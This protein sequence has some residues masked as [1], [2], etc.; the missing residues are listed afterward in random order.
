MKTVIY[1]DEKYFYK[2]IKIKDGYK[3]TRLVVYIPREGVLFKIFPYKKIGYKDDKYSKLIG[4]EALV[5]IIDLY[6][7]SN[8]YIESKPLVIDCSPEV[9]ELYN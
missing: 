2:K 9:T 6:H 5:K 4:T 1:K 7:T 3:N 8:E